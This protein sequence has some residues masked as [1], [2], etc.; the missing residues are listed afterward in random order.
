MCSEKSDF[1]S[2][3]IGVG[4]NELR[5]FSSYEAKSKDKSCAKVGKSV[6]FTSAHCWFWL[7]SPFLLLLLLTKEICSSFPLFWFHIFNQI[8]PW[9]KKR[10]SHIFLTPFFRCYV[11]FSVEKWKL[12]VRNCLSLLSEGEA[13]GY[14]MCYRKPFSFSC[15]GFSANF[16]VFLPLPSHPHS[17]RPKRQQQK[18]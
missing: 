14:V 13:L 9:E 5:R 7:T 4:N 3:L 8:T 2:S 15:G 16:I 17:D 10:K 12:K 18:T 11:C 6:S 1:S